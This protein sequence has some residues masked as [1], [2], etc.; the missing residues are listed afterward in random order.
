M[1]KYLGLALAALLLVGCGEPVDERDNNDY[2]PEPAYSEETEDSGTDGYK[3][4]EID[5]G[6]GTTVGCVVYDWN[7][8]VLSCD[9]E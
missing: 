8:T 6:D 2:T 4:I 9:W 5:R 1:K 7:D 3:Y